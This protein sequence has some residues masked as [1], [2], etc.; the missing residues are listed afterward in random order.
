[1]DAT[2]TPREIDEALAALWHK[3]D[4]AL[5]TIASAEDTAHHLIGQRARYITRTR[6][7]WPTSADEAVEALTA[8]VA[9]VRAHYAE[10]GNY[11]NTP[12]P[13]SPANLSSAERVLTRRAEARAALA[14]LYAEIGTLEAIYRARPWSRYFLVTS[15]AGHV[16]ASTGCS[17]CRPTTTYG[18]LPDL[19][20]T[21]EADAVAKL[22]TVLCSVCFASAPVGFVGG[23]LTKAQ[24][25][26]MAA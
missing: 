5:T 20:G 22:G 23:R 16:H 4:A 17:T 1:M 3:V 2:N 15:S 21:P 6:K 7:E 24:A 10:H 25:A 8:G 12:G 11:M 18:W 14:A 9:A 19:S 26:K 13:V